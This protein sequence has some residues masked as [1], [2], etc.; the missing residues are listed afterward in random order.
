MALRD[1]CV[2]SQVSGRRWNRILSRACSVVG[3]CCR[4]A[5]LP[6]EN[7]PGCP[8]RFD[9]PDWYARRPDG[10]ANSSSSASTSRETT[11]D[12]GDD[13][14]EEDDDDDDDE[15]EEDEKFAEEESNGDDGGDERKPT[16]SS[17]SK[18]SSCLPSPPPLQR[19]VRELR[20][21]YGRFFSECEE[22]RSNNSSNSDSRY[23]LTPLATINVT[24]GKVVF[25]FQPPCFSF[26]C[27]PFFSSSQATSSFCQSRRPANE[28]EERQGKR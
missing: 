26:L 17:S 24:I 2:H 5:P 4:G 19:S 22:V 25:F 28:P 3:H 27:P 14:E 8:F 21:A 6:I 23:F 16:S 15:E 10:A 11:P 18:T 7:G 13:E 12:S 20:E 1:F 9:V